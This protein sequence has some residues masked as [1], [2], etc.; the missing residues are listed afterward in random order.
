MVTD[1]WQTSGRI[2]VWRSARRFT[3]LC[4]R[5]TPNT[6]QPP[7][8]NRA[9]TADPTPAWDETESNYAFRGK[10]ACLLQHRRRVRPWLWGRWA[11]H[12]LERADCGWPR[13]EERAGSEQNARHE[14]DGMKRGFEFL[15]GFGLELALGE[16]N[17]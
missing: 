13:A 1:H 6:F 16:N 17:L 11:G 8:K 10:S 14:R 3:S 5:S 9:R 12:V 2:A 7:A 4:R 15:Q